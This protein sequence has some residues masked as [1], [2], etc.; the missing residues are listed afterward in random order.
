MA[1]T[2]SGAGAEARRGAGIVW[3]PEEEEDGGGRGGG[4]VRERGDGQEE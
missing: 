2:W 4:G 1:E 3:G